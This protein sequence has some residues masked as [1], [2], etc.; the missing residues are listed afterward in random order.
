MTSETGRHRG[1]LEHLGV[2][3]SFGKPYLR[4]KNALCER[5]IKAFKGVM[6]ILLAQQKGRNWLKLLPMVTMLM[7][8]QVSSRTGYA[9]ADL[10]FGRP[11]FSFDLLGSEGP[12][13]PDADA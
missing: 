1:V 12:L 7:N 2:Q 10:F 9:Q 8:Q 3:V 4:T 5:Q 13:R 6:R 11:S